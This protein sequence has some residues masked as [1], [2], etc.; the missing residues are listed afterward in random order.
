M[1]DVSVQVNLGSVSSLCGKLSF[2][3]VVRNNGGA[4]V[5][6]YGSDPSDGRK[7]GVLLLLDESQYQQLKTIIS[8]T[9]E[10]IEKLRASGQVKEAFDWRQLSDA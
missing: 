6:I 2:S 1:D 9:D 8:K 10:T 3:F 7:S 5:Q 4:H